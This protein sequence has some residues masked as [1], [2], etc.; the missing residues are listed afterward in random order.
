MTTGS[1][2][3][4]IETWQ[5]LH[6]GSV[7]VNLLPQAWRFVRNFWPLIFAWLA[8][9]SSREFAF[10]DIGIVAFLTMMTVGRTMLHFAT[11]RYRVTN[12]GLEIRS[13]LLNRQH[14]I[15][16]PE[17]IHNVERVQGP[18]HRLF[19]LV[20]VRIETASGDEV[21]G[22]L[23]ALSVQ[24][25]L[26]LMS[27]L[28]HEHAD[29]EQREDKPPQRVLHR[30]P[31]RDL[32]MYG[33]SS[34]RLGAIAIVLGFT[35]EA[36]QWSDPDQIEE[37]GRMFEGVGMVFL[38]VAV[39][40]GTWIFGVVN[41]L[42]R[43]WNV[44]LVQETNR[45]ITEE[46]LLTRRRSELPQEKIQ[47][48]LYAEPFLRRLF[49]FGSMRIE[50]AAAGSERAGVQRAEAFLPVV[51]PNQLNELAQ[52]AVP[53]VCLDPST[54][55]LEKPSPKALHRSVLQSV[56]ESTLLTVGAVWW[57]GTWGW[58]AALLLPTNIWLAWKDHNHQGWR[59]DP[60][61]VIARRGFIH[62]KTHVIP[63]SKLQS[64]DLQQGPLLRRW[65]LSTIVLRVAGSSVAMPL[66]AWD[67]AERL[68]RALIQ[69]P[70]P[71]QESV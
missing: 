49:G 45:L 65:G 1:N 69:L 15:L 64:L 71:E 24:Q 70:S 8:G 66:L 46:G 14:R 27:V 6:P 56:V 31:L 38:V 57:L 11:L 52:H 44:R 61:Y 13:G 3:R 17:R 48:L 42:I 21:E 5:M 9:R 58:T 35:L 20:E 18:L 23:S 63:R 41:S 26:T 32:L 28:K 39:V 29:N 59:V 10:F 4:G 37:V 16:P 55:Q 22:M 25:A 60:H 2:P 33:V 19:G 51:V 43:H 47:L 30:T 36:M 62:R 50:T 67:D 34:T 12:Q 53:G 7:V 40:S 68:Q 54:L